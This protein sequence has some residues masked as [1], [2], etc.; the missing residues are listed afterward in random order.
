MNRTL[1]PSPFSRRTG[2][3]GAPAPGGGFS[4]RFMVG[5]RDLQIVEAT[6]VRA[7]NRS[8]GGPGRFFDGMNRTYGMG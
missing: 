8:V 5:M 7:P 3:G 1:T 4:T 6:H 2:E